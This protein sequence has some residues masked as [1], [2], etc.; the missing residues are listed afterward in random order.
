MQPK[1]QNWKEKLPFRQSLK[2]CL[3]HHL[4][5][6][7]SFSPEEVLLHSVF[8]KNLSDISC[9]PEVCS[10]SNHHSDPAKQ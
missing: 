2:H 1:T 9:N 4:R 10:F 8:T 6:K 3:M 5:S 7:L